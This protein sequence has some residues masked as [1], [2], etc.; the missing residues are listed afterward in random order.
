MGIGDLLPYFSFSSMRGENIA[1]WD[2]RQKKNL[3]IVF[4]IP[5]DYDIPLL[6]A[7]AQEYILIKELNTEIL[8]IAMGKFR[9]IEQISEKLK[10]PFSIFL[11]E[12][13]EV[14]LAYQV[15]GSFPSVFVTDRFGTLYF[16]K[17]GIRR[18][19]IPLILKE[20]ESTLSFIESQCPECSI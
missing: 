7:I 19:G 16:Q 18:E 11:D 20:I 3:L 2:F 8:G 1:S 14:S 4:F 5:T 10:I 13:G 9:E 17:I 15:Q 6:K 12:E